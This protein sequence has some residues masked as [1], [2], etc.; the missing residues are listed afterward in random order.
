MCR[1]DEVKVVIGGERRGGR[2]RVGWNL[3]FVANFDNEISL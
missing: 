3:G 1:T 2:R